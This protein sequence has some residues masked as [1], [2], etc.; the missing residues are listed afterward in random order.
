[1]FDCIRD[2]YVL[3]PGVV[4]LPFPAGQDSMEKSAYACYNVYAEEVDSLR[5]FFGEA[6]YM[7]EENI[8][9]LFLEY[10]EV[11]YGFTDIAYSAYAGT[12]KSALV[13]AVPH[14][15]QLTLETY[16]EEKFEKGLQD[17]KKTVE[18]IL[19]Q[20]KTVLDEQEIKY[21]IPPLAQNNET[22]LTAPFSFKFAAVNAGL[23]W[24][25]KNDVVITEKY[26]P[27][28]RLSAV[29]INEQFACGDRILNSHCPESCRKC[30]DACPYKALHDVQW[31]IRSLRSEI[32]DYR[33]CNEKRSLYIKAHGRKNACGLCMAACPFGF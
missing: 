11:I 14:G 33:L 21:H 30:V 18:K 23:G 10:P 8:R 1:M 9:N 28:V 26:G 16:S 5:V 22:D 13:F 31:N 2:H 29:L 24:I 3:I 32:I 15:E 25:G 20:L 7:V 6:V 19:T 12:C 17:A 27:R 4:V